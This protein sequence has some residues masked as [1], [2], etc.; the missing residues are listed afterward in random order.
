MDSFYITLM[1]N[2]SDFSTV[3]N[4]EKYLERQYEVGLAA[5]MYDD[6]I[7]E[8]LGSLL[9]YSN[10]SEF[11]FK[12]DII[13]YSSENVFDFFNRINEEIENRIGKSLHYPKLSYDFKQRCFH[14]SIKGFLLELKGNINQILD[15]N[16]D[17]TYFADINSTIKEPIVNF[18]HEFFIYTDII[19]T[20][21]IG[22]NNLK[23]LQII[24]RDKKDLIRKE[25]VFNNPHY[26]N[27]NKTFINS[28]NIQIHDKNSN[29]IDFYSNNKIIIKLHFRVKNGL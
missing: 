11:L 19:E 23:I 16:D 24:S 27:V 14:F 5:F 8:N 6:S 10:K 12:Y 17:V 28:I 9:F 3:L 18:I 13:Y 22:N 4:K 26:V 2:S 21:I 15:T 25:I 29:L 20:Q 1:S 7:R